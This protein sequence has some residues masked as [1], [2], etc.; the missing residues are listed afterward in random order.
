MD[1]KIACK[2]IKRAV[3]WNA[4]SYKLHWRERAHCHH[5]TNAIASNHPLKVQRIKLLLFCFGDE[6]GEFPGRPQQS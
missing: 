2:S 4:Q 3:F 6:R 1:E 5:L